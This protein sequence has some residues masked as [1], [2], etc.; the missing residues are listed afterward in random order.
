MVQADAHLAIFASLVTEGV[1]DTH[2]VTRCRVSEHVVA[3]RVRNF[4]IA[5]DLVIAEDDIRPAPAAV[6]GEA[7][8]LA[9]ELI[10]THRLS[11]HKVRHSFLRGGAKRMVRCLGGL[12]E[13]VGFAIA[14]QLASGGCG[15]TDEVAALAIDL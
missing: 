2:L 11:T 8:V 7:S 1:L 15:R 12:E 10:C 5:F 14:V 13:D 3:H 9:L 4:A 6:D